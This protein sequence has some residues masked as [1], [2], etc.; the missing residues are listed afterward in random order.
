MSGLD[1][2]V[3][4]VKPESLAALMKGNAAVRACLS[5]EV[6]TMLMRDD[7]EYRLACHDFDELSRDVEPMRL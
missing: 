4:S 6:L 1:E 2:A 5:E 7:R 3:G